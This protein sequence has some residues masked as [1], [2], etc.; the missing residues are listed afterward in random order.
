MA[1]EHGVDLLIG[2]HDHVSAFPTFENLLSLLR[3]ETCDRGGVLILTFLASFADVLRESISSESMPHRRNEPSSF[4]SGKA[5]H[6]GK[7]LPG[8]TVVV[9][10]KVI[11]VSS[12][13]LPLPSNESSIT[14]GF[15]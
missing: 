1:N 10:R 4:R 6:H 12:T 5:Q 13:Y 8:K 3:N 2:G 14:Y 9:V 15:A 11:R 7:G